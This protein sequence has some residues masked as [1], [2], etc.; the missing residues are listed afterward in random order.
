VKKILSTVATAAVTGFVY[1][2]AKEAA[3]KPGA[4]LGDK[5]QDWMSEE[6]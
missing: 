1:G 6:R 2:L 5:I 4:M 3:K